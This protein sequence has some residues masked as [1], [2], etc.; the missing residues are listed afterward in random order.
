MIVG[1]LQANLPPILPYSSNLTLHRVKMSGNS[2]FPRFRYTAKWFDKI[3]VG[4]LNAWMAKRREKNHR[5]LCLFEWKFGKGDGAC[6]VLKWFSVVQQA[7]KQA[8]KYTHGSTMQVEDIIV[9]WYWRGGGKNCVPSMKKIGIEPKQAQISG[10]GWKFGK[11]IAGL[12]ASRNSFG[13]PPP[14]RVVRI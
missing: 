11:K 10:G 9:L 1:G 14:L 6:S 12:R 4:N 3:T 7:G 2:S 8:S 5:R 13:E